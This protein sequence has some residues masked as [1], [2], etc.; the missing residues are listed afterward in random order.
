MKILILC[1]VCEEA[2]LCY[3]RPQYDS[4]KCR[5]QQAERYYLLYVVIWW[6]SLHLR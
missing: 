1:N 3:L 6:E 4:I 5:A 2:Y